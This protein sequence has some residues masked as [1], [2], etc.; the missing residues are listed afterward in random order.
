MRF[1]LVQQ[2]SDRTWQR[3]R[4]GIRVR[5]S[6]PAKQQ[7]PPSD[8]ISTNRPNRVCNTHLPPILH[9]QGI[10]LTLAVKHGQPML[11]GR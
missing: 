10:T 11:D 1:C 8:H 5:C 6:R 2:G 3:V 7:R 4:P 9:P